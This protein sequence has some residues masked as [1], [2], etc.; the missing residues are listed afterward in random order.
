MNRLWGL[1]SIF[2]F[3]EPIFA[4]SPAVIVTTDSNAHFCI[5][6]D[7]AYLTQVNVFDS[8]GQASLKSLNDDIKRICN[9]GDRVVEIYAHTNYRAELF[10]LQSG[11]CIK[12]LI[13]GYC[14]V[15]SLKFS[16]QGA[17][18]PPPPPSFS[19]KAITYKDYCATSFQGQPYVAHTD[20]V[21][22]QLSCGSSNRLLSDSEID[23]RNESVSTGVQKSG[24]SD[25][26]KQATNE[27]PAE[28]KESASEK[29][30]DE[31]LKMKPKVKKKT[32]SSG[33]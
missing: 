19:A 5:S 24:D 3:C 30:A 25:P 23:D 6:K 16:L 4:V 13:Q 14:G 33:L 11:D 28:E 27:K 18:S 26:F 1:I 15:S 10:K 31:D 17:G 21:K 9:V 7:E 12:D 20:R 32:G 22:S 2:L 8:K 29:K